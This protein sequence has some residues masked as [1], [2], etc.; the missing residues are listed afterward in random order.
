VALVV[1][2]AV[3]LPLGLIAH[4]AD[5]AVYDST[6]FAN[7]SVALLDSSAV[8]REVAKRL[9]EELALS[10]N[11][12]AVNFRPAMQL[13]VEAVVDTDTFR[14]IFRTA[15]R[16]THASLLAGQT[17]GSGLDLSDSVSIIASTL[18][19]QG[20]AKAT[21][22]T[23]GLSSSLTDV[24][25]RLRKYHV[26]QLKQ[27]VSWFTL[28]GFGGAALCAAG[29]LALSGNRRRTARALA[30]VV[31]A[32]GALLFLVIL[33]ASWLGGNA[34]SDPAL[35]EA[36]TSAIQSAM[37]DLR[38]LAIATV[39]Y[40]LIAAAATSHTSMTPTAMI[41]RANAWIAVRR[42]TTRG[43]ILLAVVCLSAS[44][45]I[46]GNPTAF[47]EIV[48]VVFGLWVG[49]AGFSELLAMLRPSSDTVV[50]D[51]RPHRWRSRS[52]AVV[53]AIV[54]VV[55]LVSSLLVVGTRNADAKVAAAGA[56]KC[57][58]HADWCDLRLD[59]VTLP[60]A[61]NAMS[62]A[63]YP[64]WLF[65]E[66][67]STIRGQLDAGVR[68]LL[69]DTHYGVP[70]SAR[71][72]GSET[73]V[74]LTDRA[75]ELNAPGSEGIDPELAARAA[76]LAA[77]APKASG[78]RRGIYLCHNFC[79]LGAVSFSS[80]LSDISAFMVS[81]PDDVVMLVIQ[82]ATSPAD[83]A[84]A[85]EK[86]GLGRRV[87]T[88]DP[89]KP[90]PTLRSLIESG[91][92]LLV[93]AERGLKGGPAW[94]QPA[95]EHWFQETPY[96]FRKLSDFT[97][98]PKRGPANA[99]LFL[100]NHW[101]T[102]DPP[103]PAT[104]D[105]V[106]SPDVLLP[107]LRS[108]AQQR[109]RMPNVVAVDFAVRG[110]LAKTLASAHDELRSAAAEGGAPVDTTVPSAPDTTP[111]SSSVPA[112]PTIPTQTVV[113]RLTGGDPTQFCAALAPYLEAVTVW[114]AAELSAAPGEHGRADLVFAGL[115]ADRVQAF[116]DSGPVELVDLSRP[117]LARATA[118][119]AALRAA[120]VADSDL[121][122]ITDDL[123][124]AISGA[125][126]NGEAGVSILQPA[127]DR[128]DQLTGGRFDALAASFETAQGDPTRVLD[129]GDVSA[130]VARDGGYDCLAPA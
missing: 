74:V 111:P 55:M 62:S 72:P 88:L 116:V 46:L 14:S 2:V 82:D 64:G 11:Q 58:G 79:E 92:N 83:T 4:W 78:A 49:Y 7:R 103:K 29:A 54:A 61:H 91:H 16:R 65:A 76:S 9:T 95:Y 107:R 42:S 37:A 15:I 110:K 31:V 48:A 57:N 118:G 25:D 96:S 73:P 113:T 36:I 90:L 52:L 117:L 43:H 10:G 115:L 20:G 114:A 23:G 1:L 125:A 32:D 126:T 121:R 34:V 60:G 104:A 19:L 53:G 18:Q 130:Q 26:F 27:L 47:V 59:E 112:G 67:V 97:C 45:F 87:A 12:Q 44:T 5:V 123:Q 100:V 101:L 40:G 30:W 63:L 81:H 85:I 102:T 105:K 93:F 33:L 98:A 120:G 122:S 129:L 109:Q 8:R 68:A 35:A 77:R 106:N 38:L 80:V 69:I 21:Q 13:A 22:G 119:V 39:A 71:L 128:L 124:A 3:L 89:A 41:E 108:C 99:P 86:A 28:I 17:G 51:E 24:T 70:S 94:Y 75:S 50:G 84:A 66:Q 56:L 127:I 6:A